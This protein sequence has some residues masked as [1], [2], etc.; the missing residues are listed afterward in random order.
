MESAFRR[1]TLEMLSIGYLAAFYAGFAFV[2]TAVA[3]RFTDPFDVGAADRAPLFVHIFGI[4]VY[5]WYLTAAAYLASVI[6]RHMSFPLDETNG[7]KFTRTRDFVGFPLFGALLITFSRN[8]RDRLS[9][10][11]W[12]VEGRRGRLTLSNPK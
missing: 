3:D 12:R 4:V 11:F 7:F 1:N 9:Y 5:V 10:V 6:V 8:L 2:A